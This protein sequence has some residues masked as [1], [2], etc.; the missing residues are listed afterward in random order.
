ML[1]S[2]IWDIHANGNI[3]LAS[4]YACALLASQLYPWCLL[5]KRRF[6]ERFNHAAGM[7]GRKPKAA[8]LPPSSLSGTAIAQRCPALQNSFC[9]GV[10]IIRFTCKYLKG[11]HQDCYFKRTP[12][13]F[14]VEKVLLGQ[15]TAPCLSPSKQGQNKETRTK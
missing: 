4:T 9:L 15:P 8:N 11:L 10:G 13:H 2:H 7:H 14:Q 6:P 5:I 12:C 1:S 3:R